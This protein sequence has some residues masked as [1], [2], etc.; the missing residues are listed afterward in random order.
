M[1]YSECWSDTLSD[2][3]CQLR[4]AWLGCGNLCSFQEAVCWSQIV[5]RQS[6]GARSGESS[7]LIPCFFQQSDFKISYLYWSDALVAQGK[8]NVEKGDW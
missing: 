1:S 6:S 2:G 3:V 8:A 7:S 4:L 5:C